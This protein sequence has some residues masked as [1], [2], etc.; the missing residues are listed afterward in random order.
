[1]RT[2]AGGCW[3]DASSLPSV[4]N[5]LKEDETESADAGVLSRRAAAMP[6]RASSSSSSAPAGVKTAALTP[7]SGSL[8]SSASPD[9]PSTD[10]HVGLLFE[11]FSYNPRQ[12]IDAFIYKASE[13][14]NQH[15]E[16][17]E[18]DLLT[19][20][21]PDDATTTTTSRNEVAASATFSLLTLLDKAVDHVSDILELYS[22]Q[23]VF[24][25]TPRQAQ[26][27]VLPHQAG[28]N[29]RGNEAQ[30]ES[31]ALDR[32]YAKLNRQLNAAK[33]TQHALALSLEASQR[34][35]ERTRAVRGALLAALGISGGQGDGDVDLSKRAHRLDD[36][37]TT[38][39]PLRRALLRS[40]AELR[41]VDPLGKS[42]VPVKRK[43]KRSTADDG[44]GDEHVVEQPWDQG[45]EGYLRWQTQRHLLRN[46]VDADAVAARGR[47]SPRKS[48][49]LHEAQDGMQGDEVG[50]TR[51]MERLAALLHQRSGGG[52]GESG[53]GGER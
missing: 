38:I 12:Y 48:I 36:S 14:L 7:S 8:A 40:L 30:R 15:G 32:E 3:L 52:D 33:A 53:E 21:P 18:A 46:T 1:M 23:H 13:V 20:L 31:E 11:H 26:W 2:H 10:L 27:M 29:L 17:L 6:P 28:L 39:A 4:S 22:M 44:D 43:R 25:I 42:L 45:R 37:I 50:S 9:A 35:V 24:G 49:A 47:S 19:V 51:D 5:S 16:A 41:S 34:R